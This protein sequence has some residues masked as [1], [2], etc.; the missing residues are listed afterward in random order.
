MLQTQQKRNR[1]RARVRARIFG[2]AAR[3]RLHVFRS[4]KHIYA[5]LI[6]DETRN[7]LAFA[8][9]RT[10]KAKK[11]DVA[12]SKRLGFAIAEQA[13]EKKIHQVVFDRGGYAYH[14]NVK[15]VAEG[16]REGGLKF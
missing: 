5:Q 1:R 4:N 10:M 13:K 11:R 9:D 16:A 8:S 12:F 14:G 3:P 2:T 6:D 7:V 15:A